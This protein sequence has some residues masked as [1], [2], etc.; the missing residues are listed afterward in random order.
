MHLKTRTLQSFKFKKIKFKSDYHFLHLLY[1]LMTK[2]LQKEAKIKMFVCICHTDA[3][4]DGL[5]H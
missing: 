2:C 4:L 1:I 3:S 5:Q